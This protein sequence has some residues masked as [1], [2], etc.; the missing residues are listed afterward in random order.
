MKMIPR[1][2]QTQNSKKGEP[3]MKS[4]RTM[5]IA[6]LVGGG[7]ILASL[8]ALAGP[9]S[10]RIDHRESYQQGRIYRG[11]DSGSIT[12]RA[13]HRLEMQQNRIRAAEARMKADGRYTRRE[14]LRTHQM[15][16]HS[17]R[18]IYRATHNRVR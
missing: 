15:L 14:R 8:P 11:V 10:P 2:F 5:A 18:S 12:P 7:L 9:G 6:G 1:T 13:F 3:G 17:N 16:N 4:W